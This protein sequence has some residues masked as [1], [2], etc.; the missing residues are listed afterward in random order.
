[1]AFRSA[2]F[3]GAVYLSVGVAMTLATSVVCVIQRSA[4]WLEAQRM[5]AGRKCQ[6]ESGMAGQIFV[7]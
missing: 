6:T 5:S 7:A 1:M 4:L 3:Q 2:Q